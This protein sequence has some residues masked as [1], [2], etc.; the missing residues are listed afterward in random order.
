MKN[1]LDIR[2][3]NVNRKNRKSTFLNTYH[4]NSKRLKIFLKLYHVQ[5]ILVDIF[6]KSIKSL[7]LLVLIPI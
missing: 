5:I 3:L 7:Q 2:Y 6:G 4:K 1:L